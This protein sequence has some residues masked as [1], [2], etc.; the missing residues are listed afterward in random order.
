MQPVA[1][2]D[3]LLWE[4]ILEMEIE[5]EMRQP[6]RR[7]PSTMANDSAYR[8][9]DIRLYVLTKSCLFVYSHT[10]TLVLN[11]PPSRPSPYQTYLH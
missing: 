8:L 6:A 10:H 2:K 5:N 7:Q 11:L 1:E 9:E 3:E 4:E